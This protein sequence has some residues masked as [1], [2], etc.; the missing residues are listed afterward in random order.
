[1]KNKAVIVNILEVGIA[2]E[3]CYGKLVDKGIVIKLSDKSNIKMWFPVSEILKI[4]LPDA[5]EVSGTNI[6][7]IFR[8]L[9]EFSNKYEL[10]V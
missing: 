8:I 3:L 1:M 4:I 9:D 5:T 10:E 7:D 2:G 6:L